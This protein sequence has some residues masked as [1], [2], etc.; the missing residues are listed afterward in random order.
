VRLVHPGS[1]S[2]VLLRSVTAVRSD[3][4]PRVLPDVATPAAGPPL[5]ILFCTWLN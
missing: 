5:H 4:R 2:A 1:G 3:E